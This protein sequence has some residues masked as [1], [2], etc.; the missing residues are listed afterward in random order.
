MSFGSKTN[1]TWLFNWLKEPK[2]Y[3]PDTRMPNMKLS[4][5]EAMDISAYLL[6]M[7]DAGWEAKEI[8]PLQEKYLKDEIVFHLKRTLGLNA[9]AEYNKMSQDQRLQFLGER[10]ISRYGCSGCHLIPGFETAKGIGTSLSEEGSKKI[11]KFDFGFVPIEHSVPAWIRQKL[12]DPRSYDKDR[13]KRWD[14]KLIMPNFDFSDDETAALTML[15]MGMTNERVPAESQKVLTA[16]EQVAEKGR[17]LILQ[18]NCVA[19]HNIDGWGGE[20][21]EVIKDQ[22][23]SPPAL[24]G[25]GE[26]VQSDWLF[27]FLKGP[28][29]IR[30][31]LKVRMPNFRLTDE[32][33]NSLVQAFM[34]ASQTGPFQSPPNISV[35]LSEGEHVFNTFRCSICHVVGG[36]IP[37][38]RVS[39]ELA[40]DLTLA[41]TRLRPEWILKWLEDPLKLMPGTR[42][43]DFFPEAALPTLLNGNPNLQKEAIRNYIFSLGR[44]NQASVLTPEERTWFEPRLAHE[45][46]QP[47][48]SQ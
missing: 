22:G 16:S 42:M 10:S 21:V 25:Q 5:Q 3:S 44:G 37:E 40:P 30:P 32:E 38:G 2:H 26:K 13:V 34:A 46:A 36:V 17:W 29:K 15:I 27:Q 48:A 4:D 1:A 11:T 24:I 39:A 43:P 45:S 33:A 19:C 35:H 20:I 7:R 6:S 12:H 47:A 14:E 9:E 28:G 31:W 23:M 8:P 18:K 41:S